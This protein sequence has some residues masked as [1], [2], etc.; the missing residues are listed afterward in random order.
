VIGGVLVFRDISGRRKAEKALHKA[1]EELAKRASE[2]KRS[3]EDLSQFAYVA[4]HD[5]R[6][7]LGTIARFAQ[8]LERNYASELGEGRQLL[9]YLTTA[10]KRMTRLVEDL[11]IYAQVSADGKHSQVEVDSNVELRVAIENLQTVIVESGAIVTHDLL[12]SAFINPTSLVQIFQNLIGNS[13]HYRSHNT[14]QIHI[15][16]A[17]Q[18]NEWLFSCS[19]N[20]IGIAPEFHIRIFEAF[21]RL[22]GPDRP[23]TGIGLAVCRK[24]VERFGGRIWVE[25]EVDH[26]S[27][28]FFTLP[29]EPPTTQ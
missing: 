16:A 22:H 11:L 24:I 19:D 7:P 2:L 13:I 4:S 6:S 20:G 8:L 25:S 1:H 10:A 12:P 18:A 14:P 21:K 5:L 29:K 3:N 17:A 27:T 28:F 15:T 9:Q 26:G 23:G